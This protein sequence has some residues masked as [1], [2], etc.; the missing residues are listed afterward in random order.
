MD[1]AETLY[2]TPLR[3]HYARLDPKSRYKL[4]VVY[5]GDTRRKKIRLL[6][7][8]QIEVHPYLTRPYPIKPLEFAIP[9]TATQGGELTLTWFGEPGLGGNG[10]G[11]QVSEVWLMKQSPP[12]G[13]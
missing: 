10:R 11:C 9:P 13:Q 8:E 5:A 12:L 1:H 6:A 7:N 4:R 3:M 2:D